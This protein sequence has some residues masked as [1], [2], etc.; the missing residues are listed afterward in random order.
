MSGG[1]IHLHRSIL[2]HWTFSDPVVLKAWIYV[3]LA[4]NHKE[5]KVLFD[6]DL[7]FINKGQF[8]TS[9]RKF[10]EKVGCTRRKAEKLL[11]LFECDGMIRR[12]KCKRGT[13]LTVEN[14]SFYQNTRDSEDT[15]ESTTES[16]TESTQTRRIKN[17]K[18]DKKESSR[19]TPPTVEEVRA[20]C[21]ERKNGINPERFI[22]F[23]QTKG[24]MVGKNKM[25]DWKAAIRTWEQRDRQKG[26]PEDD[27]SRRQRESW[28]DP[29][30]HYF[31]AK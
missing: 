28:D 19:F 15:N 10:A 1:W 11:E 27:I 21:S 24:W 23:Y 16:T 14:Y 3:L 22:D 25:K 2:D 9:V 18:N 31:D 7:I 8:V 30:N 12:E 29:I 4:T 5:A 20:Y 17:D 13:L 6:G 26:E